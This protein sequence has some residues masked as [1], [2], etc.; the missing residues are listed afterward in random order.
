MRRAAIMLA[1]ALRPVAA[2][3]GLTEQQI[4]EVALTPPA[5]A[6]VP[7]ALGFKDIE[8]H[9]VTLAD[10]IAGRPTLLLPADFTCSEICGPALSIAAS[11]LGQ[12]GLRAGS[13]Y[14]LVI[15]GIDARDGIDAARLFTD[16]QVGGPGVSVLSGTNETINP[17]MS[18][19]GYRFQRDAGHDAVAHPAGFVTLTADGRVSRALSSLALQPTDLRLAL[20]EAGG[21]RIGGLVGRLALLCYGF[22]A[23]HGIYT[24]QIQ[25]RTAARRRIDRR[26]YRGIGRLHAVARPQARSFGVNSIFSLIEASSH[27]ERVDQIFYALLLLSGSTMLLVFGL[28]LTFA[29]R[30]RR[31]SIAKRGPLPEIVG[32]EFEIGWTSATLFLFA[33]LF[34][35]AGSADLNSLVPPAD[36]IEIHVVAKQWMWKTQHS[37]GAREIDALHI[38]VDQPVRLVMT[39]QDVIHSFFVPAFRVKQDVLPGRNTEI[40]FKATKAG[41]FPLLCAEYCGTNHSMMRGRIVV[42]PQEDYAA[43]LTQQPEGDDLAHD[44]AK[45]FAARGC[46]GCHAEASKVRAPKLAGLYGRAV[47]LSD[48][49]EVK[50]DD[51]YIRDSMLQPKRDVPVGYEAVMPSYAGLLDD[52]EIQSLTAYIRSLA[53]TEKADD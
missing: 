40:W 48:G 11:A 35:W 18:A 45:L 16:G 2:C 19:I 37:N 9:D 12:T 36:A 20:I 31:G 43:W 17:L 34:W 4:A 46:S 41:V 25:T 52:G 27:A 6:R 29:V 26:D 44:G 50:A 22:D 8:G 7:M 53:Q 30:Y 39:S 28:V 1:L 5:G 10:A 42:M 15:V 24:A 21:G 47:Q 13:D 23:V 14:S 33:F 3:A 49:R 32:R 38:P 51:A